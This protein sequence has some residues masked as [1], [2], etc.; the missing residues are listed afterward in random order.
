METPKRVEKKSLQEPPQKPEKPK[1][2]TSGGLAAKTEEI[3][4][5][6]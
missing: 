5:T 2:F 4:S 3:D 6:L 1:Y